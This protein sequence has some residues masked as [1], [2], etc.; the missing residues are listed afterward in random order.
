MRKRYLPASA[1]L[2]LVIV[3]SASSAMAQPTTTFTYD[4]GGRLASAQNGSSGAV[5]YG[6]DNRS[7]LSLETWPAIG[8]TSGLLGYQHAPQGG[9]AAVQDP[10]GLATTYNRN[11][12]SEVEGSISPDAGAETSAFD[13]AG[14]L[15]SVTTAN[16]ALLSFTYDA[17]NR[18]TSVVSGAEQRT[19]T[20]DLAVNG[21]GRLYRMVDPSGSTSFAYDLQGNVTNKT[22]TVTGGASL[23]IRYEFSAGR[24]TKQTYPSG[25]VVTFSYDADQVSSIS[26]DGLEVISNV[27]YRAMGAPI[28]WVMGAAGTYSRAFNASGQITQHTYGT[29]TRNLTWNAKNQLT[30][31]A[32]AGST[33]RTYSYD[34]LERLTGANEATAGQF[35]AVLDLSG[36]LTS[37]S[38]SSISTAYSVD[39]ASNRIVSRTTGNTVELFTHDAA[40]NLLTTSDATFTWSNFGT[41]TTATTSAGTYT[42]RYNAA[43]QRVK[44][45]FPGGAAR[46]Y[47]YDLDGVSLIGEY[48]QNISGAPVGTRNEIVYLEGIPVLVL[49]PGGG[50]YYIQPDHLLTPRHIK[51]ATGTFVWSWDSDVFGNGA[52][53]ASPGGGTAFEFNSRM[54]GQQFDAETGLRYNNARYYDPKTGRYISSDPIGLAGGLNTYVYA[55]N[56][57][58][59]TTDISG[60]YA[61]V[62]DAIFFAGG[63]LLGLAGQAASDLV[64][65]SVSGWEDYVGSSVGGGAGG[66]ALLYTGPVV[67]GAAG[68]FATNIAKQSL[69]SLTGKGCFD[70]MTSLISDTA[71]GA[72]TGYIPGVKIQGITAGRNSFNAIYKS[73]TTK[74]KN[75]A[76]ATVKIKTAMKMFTGRAVDT[77]L[78]PGLAATT[79]GSLFLGAILPQYSSGT[80]D[81]N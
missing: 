77:A 64:S 50:V 8:T 80:G 48:W 63:A 21:K 37:R 11:G 33:T 54:P 23:G 70:N 3:T 55:S 49:R 14:N 60:E 42:Y 24:L 69:K 52:A 19:F 2:A 43:G 38:S 35:S 17:L 30:A 5:N 18:L 10:R 56:T 59:I 9:L 73:M 75:G 58:S 27:Q 1:T 67:A 20:Y 78:L 62:D 81:S 51:D 65:G 46:Y 22:Q 74:F 61:G 72:L 40:G 29:G 44:K 41:L 66:L 79:A 4:A 34:A 16:G 71:M 31:I 36:N 57:P 25:K 47:V 6:Y 26:V 13:E 53:N 7:R 32:L 12:L 45:E 28:S 39:S 68:G 76:I 15:T